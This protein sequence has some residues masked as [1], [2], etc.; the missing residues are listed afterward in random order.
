MTRQDDRWKQN[1]TY[2]LTTD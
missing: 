1:S 2:P